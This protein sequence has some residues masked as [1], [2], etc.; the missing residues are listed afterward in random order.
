MALRVDYV[1]RETANN[2]RRNLLMTSAAVLTVA[3]S[4][5]LVG[6]ALLLRQGVQNATVQ[7]RG[8]V[9]LN[10]FL[11]PEATQ[12][13]TDAIQRQLEAIPQVKRVRYCSKECAFAEFKSLFANEPE[14][15]DA[16]TAD[17]LPPSFRVVPTS[18]ELTE[19]VGRQFVDRP[20]VYKVKYAE[21]EIK[22]LL[23]VTKWA[24]RFILAIA[25]ILLLSAAVLI[26]NTIR[27]AI[28][29]RR[30]EVAVMK[31]V[32]A[33]N[34]FIRVPFMFEGLV[35][36]LFG[37]AV[38]FGAVVLGRNLLLDAIRNNELFKQFYVSSS[39][40]IGTGVMMILVG[41]IVGAVGSAVAVNR[42]LDV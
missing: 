38:A 29:S 9:E 16:V 27:M 39:E 20:G 4:L 34:W 14:F 28:Y 10:I 7:W 3:V 12:T 5:A 6:G 41:V 24:Q 21:K 26:L 25:L 19:T 30:R 35:Q 37:A 33:T 2:L 40:V 8:G 32:G 31:L 23:N 17:D 15:Q 18:P 36:G 42:F 11:K 13:Q 22:T 1:A